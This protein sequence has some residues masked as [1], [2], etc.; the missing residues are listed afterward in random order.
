MILNNFHIRICD[1][2]KNLY[3][4]NNLKHTL[5]FQL[6]VVNKLTNNINEIYLTE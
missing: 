2:N 3:D 1:K 4:F 6:E 5:N